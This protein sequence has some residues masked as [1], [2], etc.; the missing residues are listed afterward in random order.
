MIHSLILMA[1]LV[2]PVDPIGA[3]SGAQVEQESDQVS[4]E[5]L[6]AAGHGALDERQ[7]S[8]ALNIAAAA[9]GLGP[10]RYEAY[11]VACLALHAT[12]RHK[13]ALEALENAIARAP[14][15]K[16]EALKEVR[17]DLWRAS[18]EAAFDAHL[19]AG[20]EA[21]EQN[22]AAKAARELTA[23][24]L[25]KPKLRAIAIEAALAWMAIQEYGPARALLL[26]LV[27]KG[28]GD[29]MAEQALAY[30]ALVEPL[31]SH[32]YS[33]DLSAAALHVLGNRL[34]TAKALLVSAAVLMPER[35][36]AH[37]Q[38]ARLA[39]LQGTPDIAVFYL[40]EA[41]QRGGIPRELILEDERLRTLADHLGFQG[42]LRDTFGQRALAQ[43]SQPIQALKNTPPELTNTVGMLLKRVA[44]GRFT[45]GSP[46]SE[47]DRNVMSE[48]QTEVVLSVPFYMG[49]TEVTQAQWQ[50][51]MENNPSVHAGQDLPVHR[52]TW[53]QAAEFCK[54][55]SEREGVLYRLP[56]EAEWEYACRA[57]GMGTF[58][59]GEKSTSLKAHAWY[60]D[61]EK[62]ISTLHPVG[63]LEANPWGFSDMHGNVYEWVFDYYA[64]HLGAPLVD[65]MGPDSGTLRVVRGGA[66]T[67]GSSAC[68]SAH[69]ARFASSF[70][71]PDVGFRVVREAR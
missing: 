6:L 48:V 69:R 17:R 68:R 15:G 57:G 71:S 22:L 28:G 30:L 54:R 66:F 13:L 53:L 12:A 62:G 55:L 50:E 65:P 8:K 3:C 43:L 16:L 1:S 33:S 58:S 7:W 61:S 24:W 60:R 47:V 59:F 31:V 37:L 4:Y 49:A 36:A 21:L 32:R 25:L 34:P 23:A 14:K 45:M 56:T 42:L 44:P 46:A 19:K 26:Q 70:K 51:V 10:D 64:P 20:R 9:A 5:S 18:S 27:T 2:F 63:K 38:L 40:R 29:A 67:S 52:V 11:L 41:I 35:Y 39:V